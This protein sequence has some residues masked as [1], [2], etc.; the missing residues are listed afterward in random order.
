M[1]SERMRFP[2]GI[3][4]YPGEAGLLFSAMSREAVE[5]KARELGLVIHWRNGGAPAVSAA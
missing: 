1:W 2:G 4:L 3:W 5:S